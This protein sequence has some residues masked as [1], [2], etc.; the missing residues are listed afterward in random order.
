MRFTVELPILAAAQLLERA[1]AP[2]ANQ[3][4]FARIRIRLNKDLWPAE[5]LLTRTCSMFE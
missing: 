1:V 3:H 2:D 5:R 4:G